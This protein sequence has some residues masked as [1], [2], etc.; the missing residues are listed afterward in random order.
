MK[1]TEAL[2]DCLQE[3]VPDVLDDK[4]LDVDEAKAV[5]GGLFHRG[6]RASSGLR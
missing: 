4:L 6:R 5:L 3:K 2:P 1:L